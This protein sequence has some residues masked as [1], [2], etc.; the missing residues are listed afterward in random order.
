MKNS[1]TTYYIDPPNGWMYGFPKEFPD[2]V[3]DVHEWLL[4]NGYPERII[5]RYKNKQGEVEGFP[6]RFLEKTL[7]KKG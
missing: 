5:E 4:Q 6:I 7:E 2:G 3:T 1:K